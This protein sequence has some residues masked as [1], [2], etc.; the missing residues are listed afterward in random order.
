MAKFSDKHV[1]VISRLAQTTCFILDSRVRRTSHILQELIRTST[2]PLSGESTVAILCRPHDEV[3][4][5][6]TRASVVQHTHSNNSTR[7][8]RFTPLQ[9][10]H[11]LD[12]FNSR[13]PSFLSHHE[14]VTL[15]SHNGCHEKIPRQNVF[16]SRFS[17]S[18]TVQHPQF[19]QCLPTDR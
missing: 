6:Y 16:K 13:K 7:E 17:F 18:F 12:V 15:S 9:K 3:V 10:E 8:Q 11:K 1:H 19:M 4:H 14:E 2:A 5:H